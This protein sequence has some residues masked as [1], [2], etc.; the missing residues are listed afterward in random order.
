MMNKNDMGSKKEVVNLSNLLL[1]FYS[2]IYMGIGLFS[3]A[4]MLMTNENYLLTWTTIP[5]FVVGFSIKSM[6]YFMSI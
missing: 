6:Y 4:I 1:V 2:F 3:Q 5:I